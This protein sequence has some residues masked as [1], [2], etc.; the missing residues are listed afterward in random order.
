MTKRSKFA[1]IAMLMAIGIATP[2]FAGSFNDDQTTAAKL[3][4]VSYQ[5]NDAQTT[6][7]KLDEVSLRQGNPNG[8]TVVPLLVAYSDDPSASGGGSYGYN[9]STAHDYI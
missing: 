4:E 3:D 1:A 6:A 9:N 5:R 7:A 2:A 8:F